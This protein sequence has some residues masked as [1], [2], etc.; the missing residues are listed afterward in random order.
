ME[1]MNLSKSPSNYPQVTTNLKIMALNE[2][3]DVVDSEVE[4]LDFSDFRWR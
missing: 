4:N 3:V 2:I 1:N